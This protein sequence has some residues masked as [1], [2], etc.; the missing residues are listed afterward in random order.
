[1]NKC[2]ICLHSFI[3]QGKIYCPYLTCVLTPEEYINILKAI[4]GISNGSKTYSNN[5]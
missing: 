5:T 1:M 4:R 2:D 3:D